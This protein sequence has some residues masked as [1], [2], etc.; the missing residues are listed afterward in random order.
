M[1]FLNDL[2][3]KCPD[4]LMSFNQGSR[5]KAEDFFNERI[6]FYAGSGFD[7]SPVK[8]FGQPHA[9]HKFV[10]ADYGVTKEELYIQL[11]NPLTAFKGYQTFLRLELTQNEIIP[12]GW[13]QHIAFTKIN[14]E[15]YRYSSVRQNPYA[16]IEILERDQRFTDEHG[17][18]RLAILFVGGDAIATY[19][20][21]FCQKP[22]RPFAAVLEDHSFG[23]GYTVFGKGGLLEELA[24]MRNSL[25][26][27]LL[28]ASRSTE[29]WTSY[30]M[31]KDAPVSIGG[32][33]NSE[34]HFYRYKNEI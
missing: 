21:L 16:F 28:V 31:V 11:A 8:S 17:P 2:R 23:G 29:V 7:G 33:W 14:A 26:H 30:E 5:F 32:I 3:E 1:S 10:Y 13:I 22:I 4:W 25:P 18:K 20:A 9:C 34:R 15:S 19:D 27:Y 6:V 12:T 24:F